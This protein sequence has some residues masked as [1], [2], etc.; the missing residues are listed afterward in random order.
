MRSTLG[1]IRPALLGLLAFLVSVQAAPA[2][3]PP[4]LDRTVF[5]AEPEISGAQ[6]SPDGRFLA[7]LRA[8]GPAQG[9]WIKPTD[10]PLSDARLVASAGGGAIQACYWSQDG[11]Y[12]LFT[13]DTDGHGKTDLLAARIDASA[14]APQVR[15]LTEGQGTPVQ[16]LAV[17]QAKPGLVYVAQSDVGRSSRDI[18]A[19]DIATGTRSLV[20]RND[21][22]AA[23]WVFDLAGEP[24][25]A[26]RFGQY[27]QRELVR[28]DSGKGT[29]IYSCTWSETCDIL[30]FDPDGRHLY[31]ASNRGDATDKVRLVSLDI[32]DGHEQVIASDPAQEVDLEDTVFSPSTHLPAATVYEGDAGPRY[33]WRDVAMQADFR[34]LQSR[35][36][37]MALRLQPAADGRHWL[38][39]ASSDREPGE[40]YIFDRKTGAL[41]LQYRQLPGLSR[42]A[43]APMTAIHYAS[44]DGL[45]IHAYLTLPRGVA[46]RSL[47]LL[48]MP[49]SGPWNVRDAWGYSNF[50]QFFAN[51]GFAVLQ[52]NF[53]GSIGY[54]KAF[55]KAGDR[56]WGEGMQDDIT[57][58]VQQL[59]KRGI[60]DPKRVAIFGMSYGGYAALAGAAF[61]PDLYVAAADMSGP[62]DLTLIVDSPV[63]KNSMVLFIQSVGDPSTPE[64]KARME[65]Q[66]PINSA[67]RIKAPLLIIQGARDPASVQAQSDRMVA[68]MRRRGANVT[69]L[70]A[71]DEAHVLGPG[72]AWVH[73]LNNQAV[74][75][76]VEAFLGQAA[77]ARYQADMPADVAQRL[78][79]LMVPGN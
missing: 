69:Y 1:L 64:G 17:P 24:A 77:G 13:R 10:R 50:V 49:H 22:G 65:R 25:L 12:L 55:L 76:Q 29:L 35:L 16:V 46:P 15:D 6:I 48:V 61:T 66:S 20:R 5:L 33:A 18:Y 72:R 45:E 78:Q 79:Q 19:I 41:A 47:P 60:A 44:K 14:G 73:P 42:S 40:A 9:L 57:A 39:S 7:F 67:D 74:F 2:A 53:R 34:L 23:G 75:A 51:R 70:L 58:G 71:P 52:P 27:G 62:S 4:L 31:L 3:L 63:A 32:S 36:P 11:R 37:D 8:D 38:V 43:L 68:A 26:I 21:V 28:P 59:V 56:Q 54:G 30:G